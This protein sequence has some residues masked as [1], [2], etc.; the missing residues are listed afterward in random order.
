MITRELITKLGFSIDQRKL[1]AYDKSVKDAKK[2]TQGLV[3]ATKAMSVAVGALAIKSGF[4]IRTAGQFEQN[5]IAFETMTGSAEL[6][7]KTLNELY[8]FAR[9][10]PFTLTG[11]IENAKLL[12]AY[13]VE[14]ENLIDT[15]G[16]LGDVTSL[17]GADKLPRIA[18][19]LGQIKTATKLRGT[20]VRQLTEAGIG[21]VN[22]LAKSMDLQASQI[23]SMISKGQISYEMVIQSFKNMTSEGGQFFQGMIKQSQTLFGVMSNVKDFLTIISMQIG[24]QLLPDAKKFFNE[25]LTLLEKNKTEIINFGVAISKMV[26][27]VLK[28]LLIVIKF[29]ASGFQTFANALGGTENAVNTLRF[30]LYALIGANILTGVSTLIELFKKLSI[31]ALA[32][33]ASALLIPLKVAAG[34]SALFLIFEDIVSFF[35]GKDSVTELIIKSLKQPF[36][37][38][39]N[40]IQDW[41]T[42]L[43][44][45]ID[46]TVLKIVNTI[47][48]I[49]KL[50][51]NFAKLIVG[52]TGGILD[53]ITINQSIQKDKLTDTV[54]TEKNTII[55]KVLGLD[56]SN[57]PSKLGLDTT[58]LPSKLDLDTS[59]LPSKLGL[60]TKS[61]SK[62]ITYDTSN[63]PKKL[64]LDTSNLPKKLGLDTSN[65]PKK[66]GLDIS[67]IPK[68]IGLDN[69]KVEHLS[70]IDVS[71]IPNKLNIDT[72]NIPKKLGLDITNLSKLPNKIEMQNVIDKNNNM[73]VM[74]KEL[75]T[76]NK[77]QN[78]NISVNIESP[79]TIEGSGDPKATGEAIAEKIGDL[80]QTQ[81]FKASRQSNFA[82][83]Y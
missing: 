54:E 57:L 34:I 25:F 74:Q 60:D 30:A 50:L 16:M 67:N 36:E 22:E 23:E 13:G 27:Q 5:R 6:G 32:A 28:D 65:L 61:M 59:N 15:L 71:N 37:E 53:P 31:S 43:N 44:G 3:A 39:L 45:F 11:V 35:Q 52:K 56:T 66:L 1:D 68:K 29:L 72:S 78:N 76:N 62:K 4:F 26:G 75:I 64:G 77:S 51:G 81:L 10:T 69:R 48:T 20:E 38:F 46:N 47:K 80:F 41:G 24:N 49:P 21:I 70:S 42:K 18:L 8:E 58:S 40:Y 63:I 33:K 83:E 73:K 7:Q 2:N 19:A 14:T 79:I 55:N 17:L 82:M 12:K 9:K